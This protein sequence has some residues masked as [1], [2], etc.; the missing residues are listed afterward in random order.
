MVT[1]RLDK[2]IGKGA[3][4]D[5][6]A[7][8]NKAIKVFK[9]QCSK[10][11]VFYEALINSMV[12][13]LNLPVPKI[14]EVIQIENKMAIVMDLIEGTSMQQVI[15]NDMNNLALYID[16]IIDLQIKIHS[17]NISVPGFP[18]MKDRL[19]QRI[20]QSPILDNSQ[21][22]NLQGLLNGFDFGTSLCH[23]D[24]HFMNLIKTDQNIVIIDWVDTTSGSPEADLCRT[25]LLYE[26]H[27]PKGF[28]DIYLDVYCK[29]TNKK[30]GDIL[31]WLPII[32]GARLT[33]KNE[34]EK[35]QLLQ[36]VEMELSDSSK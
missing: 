7:V 12:E 23:G 31:K 9:E 4:A 34:S 25:Y 17:I 33:E 13:S 22:E 29:K 3:Q 24:F 5:V 32:A 21:K 15:L 26:L 8:D 30:R 28:A 27:S 6:Y 18:T 16:K 35:G 2:L 36:L 20:S 19:K 14:Y 10:T 1:Q 11:E